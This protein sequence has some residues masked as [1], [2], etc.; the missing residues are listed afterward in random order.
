LDFF[1]A[2]AF[3]LLDEEEDEEGPAEEN[4]HEEP[5]RGSRAHV[6]C[7]R[8]EEFGHYE[9]QN[10]V[11]TGRQGGRDSSGLRQ[12]KLGYDHPRDWSEP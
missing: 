9:S 2:F 11:K 3:G 12:E 5:E 10:P 1:E 6:C 8:R 7:H 4:G